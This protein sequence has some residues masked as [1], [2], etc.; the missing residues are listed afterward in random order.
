LADVLNGLLR[1][2]KVKLDSTTVA[3][4]GACSVESLIASMS[5]VVEVLWCGEDD[6]GWGLVPSRRYRDEMPNNK[7]GMH[8]RFTGGRDAVPHAPCP[9]PAGVPLLLPPSSQ[10]LPQG[11][12]NGQGQEQILAVQDQHQQNE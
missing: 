10:L 2:A 7:N 6:G 4:L 11:Q 8:R 5:D 12:G 3:A 9:L 1:V